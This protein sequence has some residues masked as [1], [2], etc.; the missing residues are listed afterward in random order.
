MKKRLSQIILG[1]GL[2]AVAAGCGSGT[3]DST[4]DTAGAPAPDVTADPVVRSTHYFGQNGN[5]W[6]PAG[7][8][9]GSSPG[10][11]VVLL[12]SQFSEQFD[13]CEVTLGTGEVR[14]LICIN[15]VSWTH[16]PYSCFANGGRQHWRADFKC[17]SVAEV[18]VVCRLPNMETTFTVPEAQRGQ[19][20]SRFG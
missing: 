18:K 14:Q 6:K 11:L 8:D 16:T 2:I 7:D 4:D 3:D 5:L 13:N 12:S 17:S 19:V 1:M 9:H 20:C 15:N 10:N